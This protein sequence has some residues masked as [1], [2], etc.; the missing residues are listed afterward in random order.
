MLYQLRVTYVTYISSLHRQPQISGGPKLERAE[1][2]WQFTL[3]ALQQ[4]VGLLGAVP[5][6]YKMCKKPESWSN[7][8]GERVRE[9]GVE[10]RLLESQFPVA[11][12]KI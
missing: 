1:L 5:Q 4:G 8:P 3:F 10:W 9:S 7:S 2:R 12:M 6:I 11:G